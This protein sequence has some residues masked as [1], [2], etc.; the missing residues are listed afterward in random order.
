VHRKSKKIPN[1]VE[2]FEKALSGPPIGQR[3]ILRLFVTGST[4]KSVRA[5]R[6]IRTFCE[7][8][9]HGRYELNVIDIYQHPEQVKP[10]EIV[11]TPTLLKTLPLPMRRVIGDL[12]DIDRLMAGLDIVS[13]AAV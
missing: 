6:N 1:Q 7:E 8:R 5:I 4:P 13:W 12:S 2:A 10:E 9:L 11:V 3:Y